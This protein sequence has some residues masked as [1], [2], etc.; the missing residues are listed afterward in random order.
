MN[1]IFLIIILALIGVIIFQDI[2]NRIEREKLSIKLMSKDVFEYDSIVKKPI[3]I[4]PE[5]DEDK[6]YME[7]ED[8]DLRKLI[9]AKDNT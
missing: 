4:K 6:D 8:V 5:K 1:I 9:E 2:S 7:P 3:K